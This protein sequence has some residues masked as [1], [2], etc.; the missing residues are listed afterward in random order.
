MKTNPVTWRR[1]VVAAV[2]LA[3]CG[4]GLQ[5]AEIASWHGFIAQGVTRA[6]DSNAINND[7][8]LS[9][10]L[11]ELGLNGQWS[12]QDNWRV[13]GQVVYL[14]GGNRYPE[15]ARL[16]YL[17]V[18]WTLLDNFDHQLNLFIGRY[19]NQHWL[20]SSTRDVPFTRPAIIL[21]QSVYYDV[22]RDIAVSSDGLAL[23]GYLQ[24][25]AGELE[26]NWSL[27]ATPISRA[28]GRLL[29]SPLVNGKTRQKYVQ[30][31]SV[32][33]QAAG[34]QST[35]GLSL[36]D[37][38]FSYRAAESDFFADA[39]VTVQRVMLNWQYQQ[40]KWQLAA[41]LV[42]ERVQ[43][44]G[45]FAPVFSSDQFGWG[46]YIMG[47]YR[48]TEQLNV[49]TVLDYS[50]NSK[51]DKRGRRLPAQGIPEHFGY[52][53]SIML[54]ASYELATRWRLQGE[55]HWVD[56][57]GRLSPSVIPDLLN[58]QQRYWQLWAVQ[59]MYWF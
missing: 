18:D 32:F 16:D 17:F 59:L 31:A 53:Q 40:E 26:Y 55:H 25:S 46:G 44:N 36:L 35:W 4:H 42:Q 20:Y 19:K 49:L 24:L 51:D 39:E 38:D 28:Q 21:P 56:G 34:S 10:A 23:K 13:A 57:T 48:L 52:Q 43:L 33:W 9:I 11:T 27:G 58:N 41:E 30:Q 6:K 47:R 1:K 54:G 8:K 12:L 14:N 37:S 29:L 22:F 50:T 2:M 7:G 45:F 15:G 5:A 3:M